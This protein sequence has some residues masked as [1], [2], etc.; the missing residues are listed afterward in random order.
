MEGQWQRANTPLRGLTPRERRV[1]I[2][3]AAATVVAVVLLLVLTAGSSRPAPGPGCIR[4]TV[5]GVMGATELNL[6]GERARRTCARHEGGA[7]PVSRAI[8]ASC[9]DAGLSKA[10]SAAS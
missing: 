3:G 9:R 8:E 6:C 2:V 1:A 7:D 10:S 5:P 4:A